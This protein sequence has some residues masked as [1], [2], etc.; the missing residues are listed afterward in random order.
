MKSFPRERDGGRE[1]EGKLGWEPEGGSEMQNKALER[2]EQKTFSFLLPD[3]TVLPVINPP[4]PHLFFFS[5][6]K[7]S[8]V[9]RERKSAL[10]LFNEPE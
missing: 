4:P 1:L 9:V 8:K 7:I 10:E 2:P 3:Q 5:R 6:K